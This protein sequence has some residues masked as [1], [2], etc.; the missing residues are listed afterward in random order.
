LQDELFRDGG[1]TVA[2]ELARERETH[3]AANVAQRSGWITFAGVMAAL[4]GG[5][6]SLSG[7]AALSD[8]DTIASQARDV[9]YGID[10][11]ARGG[12]P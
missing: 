8:D 10:L 2:L 3:V 5:Y 7:I 4:A 12:R 6:S 11:G 9:L 1:S